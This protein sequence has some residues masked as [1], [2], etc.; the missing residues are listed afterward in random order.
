MART[1]AIEA[2]SFVLHTT[3]VIGMKGIEFMKTSD[4]VVMNRPGGGSSAVYGPD[5]RQISQDIDET[6]EGII[7]ADLDLAEIRRSKSFLDI[8]GH[9]S[10]PDLLWLG[11]DD[12]EKSHGSGVDK[13]RARERG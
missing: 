8:V 6:D 10:R 5:G 1:Y 7:Y 9:Y 3:G 13:L 11:V 4:G 12:T 2:G